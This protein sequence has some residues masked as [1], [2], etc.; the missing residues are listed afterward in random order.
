MYSRLNIWV[1]DTEFISVR[2]N[3]ATPVYT[4]IAVKN[5][6]T[7]K[8][9]VDSMIDYYTTTASVALKISNYGCGYSYDFLCKSLYRSYDGPQSHG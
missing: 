6:V 5:A 7:S 3:L 2:G 4:E 1:V 9:I 8:T